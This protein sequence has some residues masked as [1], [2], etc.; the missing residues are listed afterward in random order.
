MK[1]DN[2]RNTYRIWLRRLIMA[3]V[4]TLVIIV[5]IFLPWFDRE[6]VQLSEYYLMIAVA[7]IYVIINVINSRKSPYFVAY[8]DQGDMIVM[9][10]YPLNL[11]NSRK[12][13]HRDPQATICGFRAK[14]FSLQ[15]PAL[16][17]P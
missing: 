3:V 4:F 11:F 1:V 14:T 13:L 16:P 10:Y 2:Q 6:D 5:L 8:S 7:V 9:R 12:E 15:K 17:D